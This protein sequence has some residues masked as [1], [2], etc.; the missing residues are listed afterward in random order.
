MIKARGKEGE[1]TNLPE[2]LFKDCPNSIIE[3]FQGGR[4]QMSE[5][6][7]RQKHDN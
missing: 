7:Y 3:G 2:K 4:L 1:D 5:E 6:T